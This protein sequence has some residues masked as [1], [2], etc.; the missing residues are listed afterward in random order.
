MLLVLALSLAVGAKPTFQD[1]LKKFPLATLPLTI[2]GPVEQKTKLTAADADAL[3]FLKDDS[4]LLTSLRSWKKK[5]DQDEKKALWPIGQIQRTGH[6]L[7]LVRYDDDLPMMS[8]KET[9]LLSYNDKGE[10]LG[11]VTFHVE[12][13][14]EGGGATNLSTVDQAGVIS[15][16]IKTTI[17]M[18][19]EG[20]PPE[21]V[22]ASE[23]RGKITSTGTLEVMAPTWS[24][25]TGSYIDRKSKEELRVFDKRVFYRASD[26]K[27]FQELEGDGSTMRFKGSP[28]PYLLTWNDRRS[29]ISCQNPGGEVQLFTREW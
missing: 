11:G 24:T 18:M 6:Q 8:A 9:F 27:P 26:S 29:A 10:L 3:G 14:G 21:L 28:K 1:V 19:E 12:S 16:L 5:P 13:S 2:K 4:A 7:L 22:V 20:L 15:R 17:P 23:Q 25:R